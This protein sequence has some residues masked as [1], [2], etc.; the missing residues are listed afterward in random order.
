M[1]RPIAVAER[2]WSNKNATDIELKNIDAEWLGKGS[3]FE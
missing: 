1:T 2:L 3:L